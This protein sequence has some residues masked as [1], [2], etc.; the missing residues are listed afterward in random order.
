MTR[1]AVGDGIHQDR[2]LTG[3]QQLLLATNSVGDSQGV[4][5]IDS[6][7]V[8]GLRIDPCSHASEDFVAH[9]LATGL[10]THAIEVVE[11]VEQ[12]RRI[13]TRRF[14][15]QGPELVHGGEHHG[16]PHWATPHGGITDIGHDDTGLAVDPLE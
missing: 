4:I 16:F 1:Q 8:H 2:T 3:E 13:A 6:L 5:P 15:P 7:S 12:D 9:C 11:E 10:T 14:G